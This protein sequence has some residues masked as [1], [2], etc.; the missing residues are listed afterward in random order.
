MGS[1]PRNHPA[2]LG[3]SSPSKT[4][5]DE[6][7]SPRPESDL[8]V[9]TRA[10]HEQ[11]RRWE[12]IEPARRLPKCCH[13]DRPPPLGVLGPP[14]GRPPGSGVDSPGVRRLGLGTL[15]AAGS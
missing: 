10:T 5:G 13:T 2:V 8:S 15:T 1:S 12:A 11:L 7:G 9:Q 6:F 3:V 14:A 4:L